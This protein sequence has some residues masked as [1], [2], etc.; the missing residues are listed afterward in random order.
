MPA[1]VS[2]HFTRFESDRLE[3]EAVDN[4]HRGHPDVAVTISLG[5]HTSVTVDFDSIEELN[6]LAAAVSHAR[7]ILEARTS[8]VA[9]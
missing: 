2:T 5:I 1:Y 3:F 6:R 9:A 7:E 8:E 4:S